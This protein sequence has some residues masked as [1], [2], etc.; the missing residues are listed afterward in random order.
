MSGQI[1]LLSHL[2]LMTKKFIEHNS[3]T[4]IT[5]TIGAQLLNIYYNLVVFMKYLKQN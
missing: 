2:L 5:K 1:E 3:I 4:K